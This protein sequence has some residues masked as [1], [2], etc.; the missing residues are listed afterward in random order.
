MMFSIVS[1]HVAS[2]SERAPGDPHSIELTNE[3]CCLCFSFR[4]GYPVDG[5]AYVQTGQL[6]K[7]PSALNPDTQSRRDLFYRR[8]TLGHLVYFRHDN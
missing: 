6:G 3:C 4:H 2:G 7:T 8:V 5:A 1:Q